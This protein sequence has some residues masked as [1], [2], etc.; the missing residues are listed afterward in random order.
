MGIVNIV[1]KLLFYLFLAVG[2]IT[3]F[4]FPDHITLIVTA[5]GSA[6]ASWVIIKVIRSKEINEKY[7]ILINLALL[8]NL[9]GEIRTYYSGGVFFYY[10][11]FLHFSIALLITIIMYEYFKKNS[12]L[13]KDAVFLAVLGLLCAWE[14]SEYIRFIYFNE[15]IVGVIVNRSFAVSPYDD[16][17]LDLIWGV[18]GSLIYLVFKRDKNEITREIEHLTKKG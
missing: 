6:I 8:L 13:K 2:V 4:F 16:T 10:D 12:N 5:F 11:K 18:I 3:F 14:I 9:I 1:N 15:P 7:F 17:M